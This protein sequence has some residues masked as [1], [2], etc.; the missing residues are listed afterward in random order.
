MLAFLSYISTHVRQ[1]DAF[2]IILNHERTRDLS[3]CCSPAS[4]HVNESARARSP[5]PTWWARIW[6]CLLFCEILDGLNPSDP[7]T[8]ELSSYL[9]NSSSMSFPFCAFQR[10]DV[11]LTVH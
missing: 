9:G 2:Y 6:I 5:P 10:I 7:K 3:T 4:I 11:V 1:M 8:R